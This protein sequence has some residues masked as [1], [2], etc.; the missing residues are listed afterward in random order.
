MKSEARNCQK[1]INIYEQFRTKRWTI[2]KMSRDTRSKYVHWYIGSC[3]DVLRDDFVEEYCRGDPID[4]STSRPF[5]GPLMLPT[6][7]EA[8]KLWCF[9]KDGDGRYNGKSL[10]NGTITGMVISVMR[11]TG[12]RLQVPVTR[13]GSSCLPSTPSGFLVSLTGRRSE[14]GKF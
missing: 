1:R 7:G 14:T 5:S 8:L 13:L 4:L 3:T 12:G 2:V 9:L 11:S 6:K 10:L